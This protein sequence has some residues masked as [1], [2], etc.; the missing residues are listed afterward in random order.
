MRCNVGVNPVYMADQHLCELAELKMVPG[1]LKRLEFR[2]RTKAP[3]E[4]KLNGGH[5]SF[6]YDKLLYLKRRHAEV[7][8]ECNRRKRGGD[9]N[10]YN[11]EEFPEWT[12]RDWEPTEKDSLIIRERIV[13]RLLKPRPKPFYRYE[14]ELIENAKEF[15]ER[16]FYS[17]FSIP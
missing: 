11:L 16:L 2:P 17:P 6:F 15:A 12:L 9:I 14:G 10:F 7:W 5:L 3:L 4:F 13:E 8:K 1:M